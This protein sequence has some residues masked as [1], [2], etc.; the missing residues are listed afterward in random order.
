VAGTALI[1]AGPTVIE[2]VGVPLSRLTEMLVA[3]EDLSRETGLVIS[4][5]GHVGDG[6]LHPVLRLPDLSPATQARAMAVGA[7]L[8]AHAQSLGGTIT[9]EHG[10]GALKRP[11][12]GQQLDPVALSVHRSIKAALDPRGILNPGR[13]F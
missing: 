9:G 1:A 3:I 11:W 5:T 13:A 4:T 7:R 10:V 12:L 6:N 2:D 8:C